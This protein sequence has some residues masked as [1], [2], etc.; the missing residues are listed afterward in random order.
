VV[1]LSPGTSD[2]PDPR[3]AS[4]AKELEKLFGYPRAEVLG[5]A[6]GSEGSS[7]DE[8]WSIPSREFFAKLTKVIPSNNSYRVELFRREKRLFEARV[9][10]PEGSPL[11]IAGPA[12]EEGRLALVIE[13]RKP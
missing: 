8:S 13:R 1:Y 7:T 10:L 5:A 6:W 2:R 12:Y 9:T 4:F 3:I 11:F